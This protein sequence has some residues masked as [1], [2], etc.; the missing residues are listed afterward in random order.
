VALVSCREC[1]KEVSNEAKTCPHCGI[2]DPAP[3][4][5]GDKGRLSDGKSTA[6]PEAGGG[7][8][9]SRS[10]FFILALFLIVISIFSLVDFSTLGSSTEVD[11]TANSPVESKEI[12]KKSVVKVYEDARGAKYIDDSTYLVENG[13][14]IALLLKNGGVPEA[15]LE[16]LLFNALAFA[17]AE[18]ELEKVEAVQKIKVRAKAGDVSAKA[19]LAG[20]YLQFKYVDVDSMNALQHMKKSAQE[21]S[22]LGIDGYVSELKFQKKYSEALSLSI[23]A[24]LATKNRVL[25]PDICQIKFVGLNEFNQETYDW[26]EKSYES[27]DSNAAFYLGYIGTQID[28]SPSSRRKSIS[29]YQQ[30]ITKIDNKKEAGNKNGDDKRSIT[31]RVF[32]NTLDKDNSGI[33][34]GEA[35]SRI[36]LE[37]FKLGSHLEAYEYQKKATKAGRESDLDAYRIRAENQKEGI[38]SVTYTELS[39]KYD[40]MTEAQFDQFKSRVLD[41]KV[42]WTGVVSEVLEPSYLGKIAY[43]SSTMLGNIT[44]S[45]LRINLRVGSND[46]DILSNDVVFLLDKDEALELTKNRKVEVF[47][48]IQSIDDLLGHLTVVLADVEIR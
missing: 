1:S 33:L 2:S 11:V 48:K 47:G 31:D 38:T 27:G 23:P 30:Y 16:E 5:S 37:L 15:G 8:L 12:E 44:S 20:I 7:R 18:S 9:S 21:G 41:K 45:D 34:Y 25:L 40:S 32:E 35:L 6:W 24:Y 17:I 36:G 29:Y 14:R 13:E 4:G 39:E 43:G 26:C 10:R 3:I 28:Q 42:R 46:S 19:I 22:L